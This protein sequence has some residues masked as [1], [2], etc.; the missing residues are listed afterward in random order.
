MREIYAMRMDLSSASSLK[1]GNGWADRELQELIHVALVLANAWI[2]FLGLDVFFE[3]ALFLRLVDRIIKAAISVATRLFPVV[4]LVAGR[5][6]TI[7]SDDRS[8]GLLR[9]FVT[10]QVGAW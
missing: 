2:I 8:E 1:F 7:I 4:S 9:R 10:V 6:G 5:A 3:E